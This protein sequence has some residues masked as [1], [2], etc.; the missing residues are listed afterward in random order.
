MPTS[1]TRGY[2]G[3]YNHNGSDRS[4]RSSSAC[5]DLSNHRPEPNYDFNA[6]MQAGYPTQGT[7]YDDMV[8]PER[9]M[10]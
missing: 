7:G 10:Y 5:T 4:S 3:S 1:N 8:F 6:P 9:K 2:P